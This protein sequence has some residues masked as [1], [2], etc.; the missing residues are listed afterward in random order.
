MLIT[1]LVSG[2][3]GG[4]DRFFPIKAVIGVRHVTGKLVRGFRQ[5]LGY[6]VRG[7][8]RQHPN[9]GFREALGQK[10]AEEGFSG[11]L[12]DVAGDLGLA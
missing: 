6:E 11:R 12:L 10:T 4:T 7:F 5:I 9:D 1:R 8:D 2:G 3:I